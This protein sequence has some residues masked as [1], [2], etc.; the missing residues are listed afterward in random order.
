[1]R[2]F[3]RSLLADLN[4]PYC[5]SQLHVA[6]ELQASSAGLTDAILSCACYDY[7]VVRGIA[8]LRQMSPVFS[9]QNGAVECLEK[10]DAE[11]AL[12]WLM[13]NGSA[14]GVPRPRERTPPSADTLSLTAKLRALLLPGHVSTDSSTS[15]QREEGFEEA[16]RRCRPSGYADYL[17]QRFA[18]PSFLGAIPAIAVLGTACSTGPRRRVLDLLCG[19]G[20]SSATIQALAPQVEVI[21]A[22]VDFVNLFLGRSFLAPRA[23]A[24]CL[25]GELPL[26]FVDDSIDGVFCLDG[27]HYVRSKVALLEE[28]DRVVDE[29]GCWAF[30]HMHNASAININPGAPLTASGYS[31]RFSFGQQR[32]LP[33][34]SVVRQFCEKG[35]LD[36][37][38]QPGDD[39]LNTSNA[40][41]L[42]GSR[43]ESLWRRHTGLDELLSKHPK[44]L[45]LNPLYELEPAA[46]G[47]MARA[48]WPSE[49]L[50]EECT[51]G[52]A[53]LPE[54]VHLSQRTLDAIKTAR[55]GGPWSEEIRSLLRSF[56]LVPRPAC[57]SKDEPKVSPVS[58]SVAGLF[59]M[60][61]QMVDY[62]MTTELQSVGLL[63][64]QVL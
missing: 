50:K 49:A 42:F 51:A 30:A 34:S 45:G 55:A 15:Q 4:C 61:L 35:A 38:H 20:H 47:M 19:A 48:R 12:S 25:D 21:M 3:P 24:I 1:M 43:S 16:L 62:F 9:T 17:Y 60:G 53:L 31:E 2:E 33:E 36:L 39:V 7:P 26:P 13:N 23:F 18:N 46:D 40:L 54:S 57:Y 8:V 56:V 63:A 27:L 44:V 5:G 14:G 52:G 11:G 41:T 29:R 58:S 6:T 32:L 22:D 64:S 28:V 37:T 10:G 59:T